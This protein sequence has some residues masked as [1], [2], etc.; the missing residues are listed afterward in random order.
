M[1]NDTCR[2]YRECF[3]DGSTNFFDKTT[4]FT[5]FWPLITDQQGR[6]PLD[7]TRIQWGFVLH[8]GLA[9][10]T[11]DLPHMYQQEM[12]VKISNRGIL[13]QPIFATTLFS[14]FDFPMQL[15]KLDFPLGNFVGI[16]HS[17]NSDIKGYKMI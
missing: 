9:L 6:T 14:N 3:Q 12:M 17:S 15:D 8:P 11:M 16:C 5:T 4:G 13:K 10:N 1:M 7:S 2:S